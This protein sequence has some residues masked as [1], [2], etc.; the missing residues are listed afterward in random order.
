MLKKFIVTIDTECDKTEDWSNSSPISFNGVQRGVKEILQPLF[1]KYSIKPVYFL[2]YEV[3]SNAECVSYFKSLLINNKCELATH[4]HYEYVIDEI[5]LNQLSGLKCDGVQNSLSYKEEKH[6]LNIITKKFIDCF[7]IKPI[8]F[9]AG[10]YGISKNTGSI[11]HNLGYRIDSSITPL[12]RWNYENEKNSLNF[13]LIEREPYFVD[14]E[15]GLKCKGSSNLLEVPISIF[16]NKTFKSYLKYLLKK[17]YTK[18]WIRPYVSPLNRI[19]E[20]IKGD[21]NND[22][23]IVIMF[24]NMEVVP[25]MSPYVQSEEQS[26]DY[27]LTLDKIFS[28]CTKLKISPV[29]L[30]EFY[31]DYTK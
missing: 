2:S 25:G 1:E 8:S 19:I 18:T 23:P 10:R 30:N 24:H 15:K 22:T 29:T 17:E 16:K 14:L 12:T 9:R 28:Y 11:L 7:G 5:E 20:C 26:L 6:F 21:I 4:L 13:R 3:L 27:I 31:N